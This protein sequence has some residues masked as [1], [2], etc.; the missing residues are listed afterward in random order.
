MDALQWILNFNGYPPN[1]IVELDGSYTEDAGETLYWAY[2]SPFA[3]WGLYNPIAQ[4][5]E[6]DNGSPD[7]EWIPKDWWN[8]NYTRIALNIIQ[9]PPGACDWFTYCGIHHPNDYDVIN[10]LG[11]RWIC[12]AWMEEAIPGIHWQTDNLLYL[13][14][15][16]N[17]LALPFLPHVRAT[18]TS[19]GLTWKAVRLKFDIKFEYATSFARC[20]L[21]HEPKMGNLST[22]PVTAI[23]RLLIESGRFKKVIE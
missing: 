23:A 4:G 16:E 18:Y 15:G 2:L 20:A 5:T 7:S 22:F 10:F 13:K 6:S 8:T 12:Q 17:P 19:Y 3:S 1:A 21:I 14:E 9:Q 11:K